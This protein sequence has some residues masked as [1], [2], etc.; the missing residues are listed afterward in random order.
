MGVKEIGYEEVNLSLL[1]L[2]KLQWRALVNTVMNF[3]IP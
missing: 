1:D 2:E 3:Q